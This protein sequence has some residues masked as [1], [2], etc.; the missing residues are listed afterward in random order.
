MKKKAGLTSSEKG[1]L[2]YLKNMHRTLTLI[3]ETWQTCEY[4][5]QVVDRDNV[6]LTPLKVDTLTK[7]IFQYADKEAD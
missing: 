6:K 7:Y 4:V 1:K 5:V 2:Q 3:D